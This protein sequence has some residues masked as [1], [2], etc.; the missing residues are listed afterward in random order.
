MKSAGSHSRISG[1]NGHREAPAPASTAIANA[2]A[3]QTPSL[4]LGGSRTMM[5]ANAMYAK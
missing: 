4:R 2:A 1:P 5:A 3:A